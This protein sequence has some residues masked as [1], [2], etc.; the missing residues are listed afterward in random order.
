MI[1]NKKLSYFGVLWVT[2]VVIAYS[3]L[4]GCSGSAKKF[5][6]SDSAPTYSSPVSVPTPL[7]TVK[8]ESENKKATKTWKHSSLFANSARLSVGDKKSLPLK[9]VRMNVKIDGFRARVKMHL[10]FYN[11]YNK[12]YEG[13]FQLRLPNGANPHYL[14]FGETEVQKDWSTQLPDLG[15]PERSAK[16]VFAEK[17]ANKHDYGRWKTVKVAR[18][19]PRAK[20]GFAYHM[21]TRR[22]VD[23][24][25]LEWSG[26]GVFNGK[27]FPLQAHK[28][29]RI[30][31]GYD[32]DLLQVK[33]NL[34]YNLS[35]PK[36]AQKTAIYVDIAKKP[37]LKISVPGY[38]PTSSKSNRN[39][40]SIKNPKKK[41]IAFT[42]QTSA[43]I[44]LSGFDQK[45]GHYFVTR[46]TPLSKQAKLSKGYRR[47]IFVL[48]RSMSANPSHFNRSLEL[49][50]QI[51][52]RNQNSIREFN[53][54]SF[55]IRTSW[56]QN[57]FVKNNAANRAKFFSDANRWVLEGA[58]DIDLA[59]KT[60][61][62]P[63]WYQGVPRDTSWHLIS[64]GAVTWGE[65]NISQL[66]TRL[67]Q[68][69]SGPVFT[70]SVSLSGVNA[71]LLTAIANATGGAYYS[72]HDANSLGKLARAHRQ[73]G[74]MIKKI[75]ISG[76][77]DILLKGES[78]RV[79]PGQQ[80]TIAGR[81]S[82]SKQSIVSFTLS[83]GQQTLVRRIPVKI[84][85][86]SSL[87]PRYFGQIAVQKMESA[88][89]EPV[90]TSI[91][92]ASHFRVVGKSASLVMLESDHDY[93]RFNI[94]K[95]SDAVLVKSEMA[96]A[97]IKDLNKAFQYGLF[98]GKDGFIGLLTR[99]EKTQGVKL[100]FPDQGKQLVIQLA[101]SAFMI[102]PDAW[103]GSSVKPID[104]EQAGRR[105][106]NRLKNRKLAFAD[107]K[108]EWRSA[109]RKKDNAQKL[110]ALSSLVENKSSDARLQRE[111]LYYSV[112]WK[113]NRD[114]YY[115]ARRL[116]KT[117]PYEPQTYIALARLLVANKRY[118]LAALYY[119]IALSG[120]WRSQYYSMV[121]MAN[122]EYSMLLKK[123]SFQDGGKTIAAY[124]RKR[125]GELANMQ[126]PES[127]VLYT[128]EWNTDSTD[129]DL[130]VISEGDDQQ[131]EPH[132]RQPRFRIARNG[133]R[134]PV[135]E[136]HLG[137]VV[138]GYGPEMYLAKGL[139]DTSHCIGIYYKRNRSN[140]KKLRTAILLLSHRFDSDGHYETQAK[141]LSV[142]KPGWG[143][144]VNNCN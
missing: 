90:K 65:N 1:V 35:V 113:Q 110:I 67:R 140:R 89:A 142:S 18:M 30:V 121:K 12:Q 141:A 134:V 66:K 26:A 59:L 136:G 32:V 31:V 128:S 94:R 3:I 82:L 143:K 4:S 11:R 97:I 99:L 71:T 54:I 16:Q 109:Q 119:E 21:T 135:L 92:Y 117:R 52:V 74:W 112:A 84:A 57:R 122:L 34:V 133:R 62:K 27:V 39:L 51:L 61:I 50:K 23:P 55:N 132:N 107:I 104:N 79:F 47:A 45:T 17:F 20:A 56:W 53:V 29:H 95:G 139:A 15:N 8:K 14:A 102:N 120:Q 46:L 80:L 116:L 81:G 44:A 38:R 130:S 42:I 118:A 7:S 24:A 86:N 10:Y 101:P 137:N 129:I 88:S 72:A 60:A 98:T 41:S 91:A 68:H 58:T 123:L 87:A 37:G 28:M 73:A 115:L 6:A 78:K 2:T 13:Q 106:I 144:R 33:D 96:N 124:A 69:Q 77:S 76:A 19:V 100:K 93:K 5:A 43:N 64:D 25:L 138:N 40:Y 83:N 105:Y 108:R 75:S 63:N 126:L 48:D 36:Q 125:L 49:L 9:A 111:A 114:A 103:G 131:Y 70:Y 22:R 127:G 85:L